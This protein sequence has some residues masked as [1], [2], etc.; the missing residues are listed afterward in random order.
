MKKNF[1]E[2][3]D[4][5]ADLNYDFSIISL[6]ETWC[7]DDPR[8]ES[9]FKLN[10]Y[11][12]IFQ[13]RNGDRNGGGTCI[14]IHDSLIFKKRSD[15]CVNNNDI[16]SLSIEI[17]NK[18]TKNIIV[19]V[20]YRQPAGN[21]KVFENCL[22]NLLS[23]KKHN[24]KTVYLTG[25]FNLNLLDYKTNAKV[26]SY[27][28]I[29]FSHS[30]MPLINKPTRISKN[31]AT[32]IDHLLTNSFINCNHKTGVVKTDISDH[33]P[34]FLITEIKLESST[35]NDFAFTRKFT[36]KSLKDFKETLL[37]V[38]WD[39][40]LTEKDPNT[41][42]NEFSRIFLLHYDIF[43]PKKKIKIKKKNLASP[44]ITKGIVKSSKRKQKLY[45][46]FL[47]R[48]TPQNEE[49]YKN[50][51]RLFETIKHKSK[52]IYFNDQL[53]KY[54]SNVKK[55]WDVIKEVIGSTKS[56]SHTLPKRLIINNVE[57]L[58]KKKIAEHFNKYFV[59]V[60][61]NLASAIPI[62]QK[63]FE[64]FL[65]GNYP[66]LGEYPL[67]DDEIKIAFTSLKSNKSPGFDDISPNVIKFAFD[68]L[69]RPI[70]HVFALSMK[71][72]IF[73]DKLKI[74]RVTPIYKSGEKGFVNNYRPIS[75]LP[76]FSKL[77]E[78]IMYNRLY[79][80]LV[81][82]NILYKKQ[83]G[84]QKDH[85]TEHAILQL[86]NQIL[87][88]FSLDKFTIGIFIDLSKAFDTVDHNI[89]L[90]K[91]SFYGVKNTNLNWFRSYLSNRNQYISTEQGNT[92][93]ELITCGVPQGSILG[94]LLFLIF[95]ND[96]IQAAPILDPIMFADDT[97]LFYSNKNLDFLFETVN[98]EL[99]NISRWFQANKLS[100]NAKKTKYILF[101]KPRKKIPLNL[102]SLK[103]N[104]FEITREQSIKFLGVLIDENLTWKN[105][106]YLLENKIAKNIGVLFK[107]SKL[108]NTNCLKNIYFA[109]IHSYINYANIVWA[110][111]CQTGLKNI[112]L[113][114]KQAARIIFHKDRLT[115]SR[116]LMNSLNALNV[117]QINL[118]QISVFMYQVKN[119]IVPNIFNSNF[120]SVD[121][122]YSTRFSLNSFQLPRSLKT[123]KFSIN[124]RGPKIWNQFLTNEEKNNP[125]ILSFKRNLKKKILDFNN[126]LFYF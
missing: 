42:Y 5:I 78:R 51:K 33:F 3:K 96:L 87:E 97:N 93:M 64:D 54:Q 35:K 17:L 9:L 27:L 113:R 26:K 120:S 62:S 101:H 63:K 108:L 23:T 125:T 39:S 37:N 106:I 110:S 30:F 32:I 44:W 65:T 41:A 34:V 49:T 95:V 123:S 4:F 74:A 91:L 121:H 98:K 116:P 94:P 58:E 71:S 67:T 28:D 124:I 73:P 114:Q 56:V 45:E 69:F 59:K 61:Q 75:V 8:N 83:F 76:C 25:D 7:L 19:N 80:F 88:S 79:S 103:I 11:T 48:K 112:F 6:T 85:S 109:L 24:N 57:V 81:E 68:A 55:T 84:F 100:L 70:K 13:A 118:Y 122:S 115:H 50:Y 86:T 89:L 29:V 22:N 14:F 52:A 92:S 12:S 60:G 53:R 47:K 36:D 104:D 102:P 117:Y 15:L 31:N 111:S 72:G 40:V 1:G 126:E 21:I 77:L 90:K 99:V 82:N 66:I 16:E 18:Y 105:H 20:T 46:K 10:N 107:A 2:F 119:G 43:F 38:D